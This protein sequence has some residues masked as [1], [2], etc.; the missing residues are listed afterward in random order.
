MNLSKAFL[1]PDGRARGWQV[2]RHH[3]PGVLLAPDVCALQRL[4]EDTELLAAGFP[5]IDISRAGLRRGLNGQVGSLL[6]G[7]ENPVALLEAQSTDASLLQ[8][9][10]DCQAMSNA[11][12]V[13]GIA[14]PDY[15]CMAAYHV[16]QRGSMLMML[17]QP[18]K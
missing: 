4:P 14:Y 5:C 7:A 1:G 9:P 18:V 8:L 2:L 15:T 3:F 12:R 6:L 17:S 10:P 16:L 11:R 13:T